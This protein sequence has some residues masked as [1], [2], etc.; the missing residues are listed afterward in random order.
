MPLVRESKLTDLLYGITSYQ[1]GKHYFMADFD[2][3]NEEVLIERVG[4][5]LFDKYK[6][7]HVYMIRTGKGFHIVSF[8]SPMRIDRYIRILK[9]MKADPLFIKWV[10]RVRYGVLRMSRRS[11]HM[12]VPI[13]YKI[14]LSPYGNEEDEYLRTIYLNFLRL[15]R[16]FK[17]VRRV[18]VKHGDRKW[19]GRKTHIAK[20]MQKGV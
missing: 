13:L 8:S 14:F 6:L 12:T 1:R 18:V 7:G 17:K 19:T 11:S 3:I 4:K 16:R 5:I 10:K 20:R 2:K 15:E 9:D